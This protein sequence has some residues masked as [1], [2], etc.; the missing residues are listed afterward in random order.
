MEWSSIKQNIAFQKWDPLLVELKHQGWEG[1]A[2][3]NDVSQGSRATGEWR[4]PCIA[5]TGETLYVRIL[6]YSS[7]VF[8]LL[9]L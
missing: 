8:T 3:S 6:K 5:M 2:T 1:E 4:D 9:E 7:G